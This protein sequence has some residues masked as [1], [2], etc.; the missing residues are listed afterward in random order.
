MVYQSWYQSEKGKQNTIDHKMEQCFAYKE[1]RQQHQLQQC[2]S[3]MG[4]RSLSPPQPMLEFTHF[5]NLPSYEA[6]TPCPWSLKYRKLGVVPW[7]H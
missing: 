1:K 3:L 7:D 4:S 6:L 5:I 2:E